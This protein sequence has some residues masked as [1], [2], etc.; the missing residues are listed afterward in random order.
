MKKICGLLAV[1][2]AVAAIVCAGVGILH[3]QEEKNAGEVY[4]ELKTEVAVEPVTEPEPE[5]IQEP[6]E[7][8]PEEEPLE[9]PVDFAALQEQNPDVY[10]WIRIPGT[11]VDYPILQSADDNGYY[12]TH[13]I[14]HEKKTEGAIYTEDYNSKDFEDPNTVIYGHNMKNGSMFRTLHNYEDRS[15]F[16][17]NREVWIYLPDRILEYRIFAAYVYDN[18]HL[19]LKLVTVPEYPGILHIETIWGNSP[20]LSQK[21][22]HVINE[23]QNQIIKGENNP[24][25]FFSPCNLPFYL[26]IPPYIEKIIT[27]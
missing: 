6:E 25:E 2:A 23:Y 12:L 26:Y 24:F 3:Y 18:R 27:R 10:A 21:C 20:Y 19:L 14:D 1:I 16:D 17:E 7:I 5:E 22:N 15:F 4:E 8:I 11:N 13:T 9:I